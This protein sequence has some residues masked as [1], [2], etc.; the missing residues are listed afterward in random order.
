MTITSVQFV[1]N[2]SIIFLELKNKRK[3]IQ[4][5][6]KKWRKLICSI[7]CYILMSKIKL[8]RDN[9]QIKFSF[10]NKNLNFF[11]FKKKRGLR[12]NWSRDFGQWRTAAN[13]NR[14]LGIT[15]QHDCRGWPKRWVN[16][17]NWAHIVC[18][19][20]LARYPEIDIRH[21]SIGFSHDCLFSNRK[22][23]KVCAWMDI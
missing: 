19:A 23:N 20:G 9:V 11:L 7:L 12:F 17:G 15:M 14:Y 8:C 5:K 16:C 13:E 3:W 10:T 6:G 1:G 2:W 21:S 4:I 18:F 22:G